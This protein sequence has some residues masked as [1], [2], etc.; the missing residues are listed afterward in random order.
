MVRELNAGHPD[1]DA[2]KVSLGVLGVISQI[3]LAMQPLFKRSVTFVD[4]D[5]S[6]LP[7][8]VTVWG[9]LYEFGDIKWLPQERKVVYRKDDRVGVSSPGNGLRDSPIFRASPTS[10]IVAARAEAERLEKNGTDGERCQAQRQLAATEEK[11]AY[12]FTNDGVN[13]TGYPVVGLQHLMQASGR[14]THK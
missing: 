9:H 6:D 12:G 14:A 2:A 13:F 5:E 11:E 7:A 10:T 4:R 1:L 8:K 3:T